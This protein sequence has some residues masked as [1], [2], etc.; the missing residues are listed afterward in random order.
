MKNKI[1]ILF[2]FNIRI[3]HIGKKDKQKKNS[4]EKY[5]REWIERSRTV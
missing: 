5:A 2:L 4:Y 3:K 1:I